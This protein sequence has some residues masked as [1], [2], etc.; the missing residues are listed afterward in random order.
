MGPRSVDPKELAEY[1]SEEKNRGNHKHVTR[2]TVE[3]P[4]QRLREGVILVD[5][6]GIGSL[7]TSG[8]AETFAYLPRCDLSV[9][10]IDAGST[11]NQEDLSLLRDLYEAGVPAQVLLSKADLL[12][13]ED[14]QRVL[15]YIRDQLRQELN[16]DVAVH[17]VS[18]MGKDEALLDR[19]FEHE[20][21][22][23]W[24]RQRTLTEESLRRKIARLRESVMAVLQT[25]LAKRH[26]RAPVD[27]D[28]R[29][30]KAV[31]RLLDEADAAIQQAETR[32]RDWS[33]DEAALVEI[34]LQDVA[35]TLVESARK[36]SGTGHRPLMQVIHGSL[37]QIGQMAREVVTGLQKTLS[38]VLEVLEKT[39]P[40]A[41]ADTAAIRNA[42]LGGLPVIDISP[43]S[44]KC[45]CS[46]LGWA[47]FVP[48]LAP[49]MAR[50]AVDAQLAD[51][52]RQS[53]RLHNAQLRA[54]LKTSISL[55]VEPYQSQAEVFREQL[56][57]MSTDAEPNTATDMADLIRDLNELEQAGIGESAFAGEVHSHPPS[58]DGEGASKPVPLGTT[59]PQ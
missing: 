39:A 14:R 13:A 18:T 36:T 16:L 40:L 54:W 8:S 21:E 17:P 53:V 49:W 30:L 47:T 1:A 11:L 55:V 59:T 9:V 45:N 23:L 2:I 10:L 24:E 20:I 43:L 6:P 41:K 4:S 28:G 33:G 22:P 35:K 15:Q 57:R 31:E 12:T 44:G 5:T 34:I 42:P 51:Q 3:I 27:G 19:W 58:P 37:V 38:R 32:H 7:A 50:R 52:L 26:G 56:R 29:Q 25:L 46:I 48:K